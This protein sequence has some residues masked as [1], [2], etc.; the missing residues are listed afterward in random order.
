MNLKK[1]LLT[2]TLL[3]VL[4]SAVYAQVYTTTVTYFNIASVESFT[5]TL[6]GESA[7]TATG[8]GAAT[9]NIEFNST[10]GTDDCI[11]ARVTGGTIQS[12]GTPI[13]IVENTGT[14]NIDVTVNFTVSPPACVKVGGATTFAGACAG[15]LIDTTAVTLQSGLTPT[16]SVNWYEKANFTACTSG[17]ST[18]RTQWVYGVQS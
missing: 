1:T 5:V 11:N 6:P 8:G 15:S 18:T 2:A 7:V 12:D 17:D 9:H 14:V 10:D 13:F 4:A 3:L 16:S